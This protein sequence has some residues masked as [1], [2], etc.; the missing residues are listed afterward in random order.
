[1]LSCFIQKT[2]PRPKRDNSHFGIDEQY[3][4]L[5]FKKTKL[6]VKDDERRKGDCNSDGRSRGGMPPTPV[7]TPLEDPS[8]RPQAEQFQQGLQGVYRQIGPDELQY[9]GAEPISPGVSLY[10]HPTGDETLATCNYVSEIDPEVEDYMRD[11]Y[12]SYL[13]GDC[14]F[15]PHDRQHVVSSFE[16]FQGCPNNL[17]EQD[18]E[19]V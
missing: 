8:R 18:I 1:M 7:L 17:E 3:P 11:G 16:S 13:D 14:I 9:L 4:K 15:L 2:P 5:Q 19:L 12:Y 6:D 10:S